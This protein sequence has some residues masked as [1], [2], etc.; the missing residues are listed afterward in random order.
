MLSSSTLVQLVSS[1]TAFAAPYLLTSRGTQNREPSFRGKMNRGHQP[2]GFSTQQVQYVF[3]KQLGHLIPTCRKRER[4]YG[5]SV[6][7]S[8]VSASA[9]APASQSSMGFLSSDQLSQIASYLTQNLGI[10][11]ASST[12][13]FTAIS[14]IS[15]DLLPGYLTHVSLKI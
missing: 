2:R 15:G 13:N 6:P 14:A 7:R 9:H 11:G 4:L 3:C 10:T 1:P 8:L 12:S 5:P